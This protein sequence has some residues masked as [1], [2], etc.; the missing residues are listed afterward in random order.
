[1]DEPLKRSGRRDRHWGSRG[2]SCRVEALLVGHEATAVCDL[3]RG[4]QCPSCLTARFISPTFYVQFSPVGTFK[5]CHCFSTSRPW[6]ANLSQFSCHW[7]RQT[8]AGWPNDMKRPSHFLLGMGSWTSSWS[9]YVFHFFCTS[10]LP[11]FPAENF[12]SST[13]PTWS[14]CEDPS[15]LSSLIK[16][17]TALWLMFLEFIWVAARSCTF[18]AASLRTPSRLTARVCQKSSP[19]QVCP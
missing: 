18:P 9:L 19:F 2:S 12:S 4:S 15:V 14:V 1:M 11:L 3:P 16:Y 6:S 10:C 13:D 8:C 5:I 7:R 17:T